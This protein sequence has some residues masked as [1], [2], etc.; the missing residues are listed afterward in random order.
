MAPEP[1]WSRPACARLSR[2]HFPPTFHG[3]SLLL[4]RCWR[5]GPP[6]SSRPCRPRALRA[7]AEAHGGSGRRWLAFLAPSRSA[8]PTADD[9]GRAREKG[10]SGNRNPS[11][12]A[13]GRLWEAIR[14]SSSPQRPCPRAAEFHSVL[15]FTLNSLPSSGA[16]SLFSP[17]A[18]PTR[19]T[20]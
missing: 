2:P 3:G 17:R 1:S 6:R 13:G 8:F 7:P 9:A 16:P 14:T 10:A 15:I 5:P 4:C 18:Q 11:A 19:S 12:L 20:L